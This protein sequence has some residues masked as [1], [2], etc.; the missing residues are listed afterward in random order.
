MNK[1]LILTASMLVLAVSSA[2]SADSKV[3]P[4]LMCQN[5][6]GEELGDY[7][8]WQ[9]SYRV[10][11]SAVFGNNAACPLV[12]RQD[13]GDIAHVFVRVQSAGDLVECWVF[14]QSGGSNAYHSTA[15]EEYRGTGRSSLS[16]D[17]DGLEQDGGGSVAVRCNLGPSGQIRSIRYVQ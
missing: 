8:P 15:A 14:S 16:F 13:A 5:T 11:S 4:G 10:S 1:M 2:A 17:L 9:G 6:A 7:S 12:R 3:I